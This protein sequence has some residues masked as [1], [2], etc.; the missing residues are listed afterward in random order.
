MLKLILITL[1]ICGVVIA[2][3]SLVAH[4]QMKSLDTEHILPWCL[5]ML[6]SISLAVAVLFPFE[7]PTLML[8][9]SGSGGQTCT[10]T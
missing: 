7:T 2:A 4:G 1:A 9:P 3:L 5:I 8:R 6:L 10:L